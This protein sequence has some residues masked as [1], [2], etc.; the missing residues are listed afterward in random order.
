MFISRYQSTA[1]AK[2]FTTLGYLVA[3]MS[4]LSLAIMPRAKF[5]QQMLFNIVSLVLELLI[6]SL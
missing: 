2:T 1:F 4:I 3:I 5:L 6:I